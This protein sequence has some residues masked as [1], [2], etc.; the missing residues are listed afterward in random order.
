MMIAIL[1]EQHAPRRH[2]ERTKCRFSILK[3][4]DEFEAGGV[5]LQIGGTKVLLDLLKTHH[6]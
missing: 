4:L 6:H 5:G 2:G 1:V 3:F